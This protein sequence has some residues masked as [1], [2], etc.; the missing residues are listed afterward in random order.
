MGVGFGLKMQFWVGGGGLRRHQDKKKE[1]FKKEDSRG[2][3]GRDIRWGVKFTDK[4][5]AR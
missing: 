4:F 3:W 5:E 2:F 1:E